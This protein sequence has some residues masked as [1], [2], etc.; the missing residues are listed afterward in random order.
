VRFRSPFL[1]L[2]LFEVA[3]AHVAPRSFAEVDAVSDEFEG[4]VV[5]VLKDA[6]Y[7]IA[8]VEPHRVLTTWMLERDG[9][10]TRRERFIVTWDGDAPGPV[11]LFVRHQSQEMA[12]GPGRER[13][14]PTRHDMGAQQEILDAITDRIL[15]IRSAA[16]PESAAR[17]ADP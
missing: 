5:D 3:C 13:W 9:T 16:A 10:D 4:P 7:R 11:T 8:S 2:L 12:L 1:T 6:G 14:G 17:S 15:P